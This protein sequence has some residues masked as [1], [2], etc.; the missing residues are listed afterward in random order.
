MSLAGASLPT[1]VGR[2]MLTLANQGY[3]PAQKTIQAFLARGNHPSAGAQDAG[4]VPAMRS[5]VYDRSS[6]ATPD[7]CP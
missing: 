4:G 2:E 1:S 6:R 3:G 5:E 7:R